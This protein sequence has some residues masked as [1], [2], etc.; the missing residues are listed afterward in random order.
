M[1]KF[2]AQIISTIRNEEDVGGWMNILVVVLLAV[3]WAVWGVLKTKAKKP[4]IEE[5]DEYLE[6]TLKP[7]EPSSLSLK[8]D[9]HSNKTDIHTENQIDSTK[10]KNKKISNSASAQE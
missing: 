7:I 9:E 6:D 3:S 5:E 1:E 4:T 8:T 10:T 2:A